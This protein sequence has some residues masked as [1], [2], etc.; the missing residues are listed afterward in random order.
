VGVKRGG[1]MPRHFWERMGRRGGGGVQSGFR[2][3][4]TAS[5]LTG[6]ACLSM[7]GRWWGRLGQKGRR[8]RGGPR[9][10]QKGEGERWATAG[11]ETE[12]GWIKSFRILFE[13]WIFGK[14]WKFAQVDSEG[15][16]T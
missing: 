6:R 14:L 9:L 5:R 12:N 13:I 8:E 1:G 2:R 7:R 16:L 11:P 4:K 15:I 3:K 10:G